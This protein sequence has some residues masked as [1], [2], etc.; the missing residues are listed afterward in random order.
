MSP[1]LTEQEQPV[2]QSPGE[3]GVEA[4]TS[5]GEG[6]ASSGAVLGIDVSDPEANEAAQMIQ[7]NFRGHLA[8]E[9]VKGLRAESTTEDLAQHTHEVHDSESQDCTD[10]GRG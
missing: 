1:P 6:V 10:E 8:R 7:S 9:R 4:G 5:A 3:E 2:I